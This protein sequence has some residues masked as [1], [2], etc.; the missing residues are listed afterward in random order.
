[1]PIMTVQQRL[2]QVGVI[3]LGEKRLSKNNK[4]YPAKLETFRLTSPA[5]HIIEA[6]AAKYGGEV[7]DWPDAPDGPQFQVTTQSIALD[8]YV[9]PQK[10]DPNM[11]L[12]GNRHKVRHCDGVTEKIR[13]TPCMCEAAARARYQK[14]G[15]EFPED[16]RFVRD[17]RADC[18]PTTRISVALADISDGQWKVEAHGWNAAAELPTQASVYLAV[19]Q[20]PVPAV[21]RM[22][23][24]DEPKLIIENGVEKVDARKFSVP[25]LDFGDLFTMRQALTGGVDAAVARALAAQKD[26]PAIE[27][28]KLTEAAVLDLA[29]GLDTV[30]AL[31]D[32]WRAAGKDGALTDA[33]RQVL[34]QRSA[35]I[36]AA[37][38]SAPTE[39]TEPA[40][41]PATAAPAAAS[42]VVPSASQ[43]VDA[44]T[45]PD[46][47]EVWG[48][49][50]REAQK[51]GWN[52]KGLYA[53]YA[54]RMGH[55]PD[56]AEASGWKYQEFLTA[57]KAG[58]VSA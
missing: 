53:K 50:V 5:R 38:K 12:W 28:S 49:I 21:L 3:R 55:S 30:E 29:E 11:E 26:R 32:L 56:D 31:Q 10:I 34:Q 35:E 45:E 37:T 16:G 33:V 25:V 44:E 6:V 2:K 22:D 19:A 27:A 41:P 18:K 8:V 24:R 57:L 15:M 43:V 14:A 47:D 40:P 52:L 42:A 58:E 1:M 4:P 20:R 17:P 23:H 9:L 51:V 48:S 36:Q 54:E 13:N 7:R 39:K 46:R